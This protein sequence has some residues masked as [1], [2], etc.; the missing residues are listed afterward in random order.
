ME[1]ISEFMD[2]DGTIKQ[3]ASVYADKGYDSTAIRS[4]LKNRNPIARIPLRKSGKSSENKSHKKYNSVRCVAEGLF[5]GWLKNGFHRTGIRYERRC[6]NCPAFVGIASFLMYCRVL[7]RVGHMWFDVIMPED[8][9]INGTKPSLFSLN[10]TVKSF[11][12]AVC[13]GTVNSC[14]DVFYLQ[15][16]ISIF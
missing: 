15:F 7:R 2:D 9:L 6:E 5:F 12:L 1:S 3:I 10:L 16:T 11:E 13:L 14:H 4:Y 8:Q